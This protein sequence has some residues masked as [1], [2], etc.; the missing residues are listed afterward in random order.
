MQSKRKVF[1]N[2]NKKSKLLYIFF[3]FNDFRLA[4]EKGKYNVQALTLK[5]NR[6][7]NHG[8]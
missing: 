2:S 4:S 5:V 1:L 3:R 8:A 7:E 6:V